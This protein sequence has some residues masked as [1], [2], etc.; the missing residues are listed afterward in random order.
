MLR[1]STH[2]TISTPFA[3]R[4]AKSRNIGTARRRLLPR[5]ARNRGKRSHMRLSMKW[6]GALAALG[7]GCWI[8]SAQSVGKLT[9]QEQKNQE[10]ATKEMKEILQ[11]GHIEVATDVMAPGYIQHNPKVPGGRD[12]F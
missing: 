1:K 7:L 4:T 11:Y 3:S 8:L 9:A 12:A 5:P 10:I 6:T 2:T